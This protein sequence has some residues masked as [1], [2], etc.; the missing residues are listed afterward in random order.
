[1]AAM[2]RCPQPWARNANAFQMVCAAYPL[3]SSVI[4]GSSTWVT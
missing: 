4:T 2:R 1:L 3:R